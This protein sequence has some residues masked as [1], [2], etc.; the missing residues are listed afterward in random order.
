MVLTPLFQLVQFKYDFHDNR[1]M[2]QYICTAL[3]F[4]IGILACIIGGGIGV[5]RLLYPDLIV[6]GEVPLLIA[7][8]ALVHPRSISANRKSHQPMP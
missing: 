3:L 6:I 4:A 8:F 7:C 2:R 5:M 1:R